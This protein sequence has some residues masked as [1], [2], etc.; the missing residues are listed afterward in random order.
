MQLGQH[1]WLNKPG[2]RGFKSRP[3]H[4]Q[5]RPVARRGPSSPFRPCGRDRGEAVTDTRTPEQREA[6]DAL[7]EAVQR[8]ARLQSFESDLIPG[9]DGTEDVVMEFV[10]VARLAGFRAADQHVSRY[11]VITNG[12][13]VE[14]DSPPFHSVEGLLRNGLR[15]LDRQWNADQ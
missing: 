8:V 1:A 6:S 10:V 5:A 13:G 9:D 3:C 7:R 2:G 15:A 11:S 14:P 4:Q 12:D